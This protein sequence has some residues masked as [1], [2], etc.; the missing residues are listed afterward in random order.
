MAS[1]KYHIRRTVERKARQQR[2][3][4][5]FKQANAKQ[6][7]SRRLDLHGLNFNVC[8]QRFKQHVVELLN[9]VEQQ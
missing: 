7:L 2:A 3:W 1:R 9:A 4:R 8:S 5:L 6:K